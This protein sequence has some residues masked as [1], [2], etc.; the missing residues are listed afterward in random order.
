MLKHTTWFRSLQRRILIRLF[1]P[2][3]LGFMML[4][5]VL[6]D[7]ATG[8]TPVTALML[9]FPG[10]LVGFP[11]GRM[12]KVAWDS[13]KSQVVLIGRQLLVF[14]AYLSVRLVSRLLL[15]EH[16]AGVSF[17]VDVISLF[18]IGSMFGYSW[19]LSRRVRGALRTSREQ[20][21]TR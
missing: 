19:A 21:P 12:T 10:F 3:L 1:L 4:V 2:V 5:T 16:F 11:F 9:L 13:E 17:A 15:Y 8:H 20:T 14:V 6:V 7:V 18:S